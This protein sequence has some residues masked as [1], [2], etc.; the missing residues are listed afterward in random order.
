MYNTIIRKNYKE[1]A[2]MICEALSDKIKMEYIWHATLLP[3]GHPALLGH[4]ISRLT[5]RDDGM[6]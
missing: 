2:S 3:P 6:Q 4:K 1:W 5:G